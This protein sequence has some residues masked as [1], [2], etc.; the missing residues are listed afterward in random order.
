MPK[1]LLKKKI[2]R[3]I[4]QLQPPPRQYLKILTRR[5]VAADFVSRAL[6]SQNC[7]NSGL[8]KKLHNHI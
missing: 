7:P 4:D 5:S 8:A 3:T 2:F 1:I 6:E